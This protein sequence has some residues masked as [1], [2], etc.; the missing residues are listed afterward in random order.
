[1]T[2]RNY[3]IGDKVRIKS[4][5]KWATVWHIG[6][7]TYMLRVR[8]ARTAYERIVHYP[9]DCIELLSKEES[10]QWIAEEVLNEIGE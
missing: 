10:D 5:N 7:T 2:Y 3:K 4:N 9:G 1:M 6:A 8:N